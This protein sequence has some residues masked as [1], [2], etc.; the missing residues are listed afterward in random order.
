LS[1]TRTTLVG[2]DRHLRELRLL[3]D[4]VAAGRGYAVLLSGEAGAGKTV[5]AEEASLFAEAAGVRVGWATCWRSAAAPLSVWTDLVDAVAGPLV[6]PEAPGPD[7]DP[8]GA[9]S[10]WVRTLVRRLLDALKASP[11]LLVVDDVQWADPLSLHAVEVLAGLVRSGPVGLL[12]TVRDDGG[13]PAGP[14]GYVAGASRHLG[15]P[16]LTEAELGA[17][18]MELTGR[19][20]TAGTLARLHDRTAGN[21][22]FARELLGGAG[23]GEDPSDDRRPVASATMAIFSQRVASLST[24]CQQVLEAASVIGRRFRL[25]IL[26]E[27]LAREPEE[28]LDLIGEADA[29]GLVRGTGIGGF[30]FAHPLVAEACY[31]GGGLPRRVRL[32]RDVAEAMERLRARGI[33]VPAVEIAHHFAQ[34]AAAGV[35]AKAAGYAAI[36]GRDDMERLAYEDA[37]RDFGLALSARE[38]C[39]ADDEVLAALLLDLGDAQAATG[40][41]G[42]AR[43]AYERAAAVAR[44]HGWPDVLARA[45]L[46]VG[47][48]PG[49]FEVPPFDDHQ[50]ALLE[51]GAAAAE[52]TVRALVLARLSVALALDPLAVP[53]RAALSNEAIE[54]A[55]SADDPPALGYALASWCDVI[56]GPE[57]VDDRL[58]ATEEILGCAAATRDVR[59][60]LLGRR[61]RVVA[62]LEAG[63][64]DDVDSE[65]AAFASSVERV[66]QPVYSWYVPL[67]QAMRACMEG[68][69]EV[70][71]RLR[72]SAGSIGAAA[73]SQNALLLVENQRAM[74]LCEL[75][76]PSDTVTFF[77]DLLER[78]PDY[79]IMVRPA[80]AYSS[81]VGGDTE[82]AREIVATFDPDTYTVDALGSEFLSTVFIAAHGAWLAGC[83]DHAERLYDLLLPYR[84]RF[85]IDGIGGYFAGSVERTLGVLAAQRRELELAREHF[86]AALDAHRRV[87]SPVL[88]AAT[89]R[90]AGSCLDDDTMVTEAAAAFDALGARAVATPLASAGPVGADRCTFRPEGDVWLLAWHGRTAHVRHTKGMADLARLLATPHTEVHVLDLVEAG[91]TLDTGPGDD[92]IDAAA[93]RQ[94]R[95]RLE[96]IDSELGEA[97]A[98][99]DMARSERLHLERDALIAELSAA[100]GLGGRTRRRGRSS[101]RA[102]SAVTQRIRDTISRIERVHPELAAH[103]RRSIRTGTF[104]AYQPETPVEWGT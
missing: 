15:V 24:P 54:L 30:E 99:G 88:V 65:I 16:P 51:E 83:D 87:R 96:E 12:C 5:L 29:A 89:L 103:L 33:A 66:G 79:S 73:H 27:A 53:R 56:P 100:Y 34:A 75:R 40:D 50:I 74:L 69:F 6:V 32:H 92:V 25:D 57:A 13:G 80:L 22:L 9:R 94:Y 18:A 11:T 20:M 7:A 44:E 98:H 35:A 81:V 28:L 77:E 10:V 85:A 36:A 47:S 45:A 14:G 71:A 91:P 37:V 93:R 8:E 41:R 3:V 43:D 72:A 76:D 101:E 17:L 70:A 86:A 49:G 26:G 58:G 1:D 78:F 55:R 62:L 2:R 60:E 68:H 97:D 59:L 23:D 42:A 52:G 46:G 31:Q 4:G 48:G 64:T 84:S 61:L 38:L 67:W 104:C 39:P 19:T 21:V 63:R 95:A 102:R 82:R 90:D